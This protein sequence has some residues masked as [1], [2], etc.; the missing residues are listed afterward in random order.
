MFTA[1]RR[2]EVSILHRNSHT[3]QPLNS[4][5]HAQRPA[6][7]AGDCHSLLPSSLSPSPAPT[8]PSSRCHLPLLTTILAAPQR[9]DQL[10][11]LPSLK[12]HTMTSPI[13]NPKPTPY[14]SAPPKTHQ[15]TRKRD[16]IGL[17]AASS[18][19]RFFTLNS[20]LQTNNLIQSSTAAESGPALQAKPP[21]RPR[22]QR[23]RI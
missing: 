4:S 12:T 18:S 17:V 6:C 21:N 13:L 9:H 3:A 7:A 20:W 10:P 15:L 5:R 22:R 11:A 14:P 1:N 23:A 16:P 19:R 8:T 2:D